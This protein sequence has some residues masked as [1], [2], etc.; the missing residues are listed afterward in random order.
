MIK[1]QYFSLAELTASDYATRHGI[2]NTPDEMIVEALSYLVSSTLDHL[3][4]Y[5]KTP[6]IVTSGYRCPEL[7][8]AIGGSDQ[9]QHT[10]GMAADIKAVGMTAHELFVAVYDMHRLGLLTRVD[11]CILEFNS[12]VHLSARLKQPREQFLMAMKKDGRT[13]YDE[14]LFVTSRSAV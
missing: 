4:R 13:V 14:P 9:S 12:W 2:D 5:V 6:I 10:Y 7:N 11:Q 3:R 8:A 1:S